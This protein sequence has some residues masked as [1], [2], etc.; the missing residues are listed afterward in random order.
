M[1]RIYQV[2]GGMGSIYKKLSIVVAAFEIKFVIFLW[3]VTSLGMPCDYL[4]K[5]ER[6]V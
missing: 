3:F 2:F 5:G 1:G 6:V 4:S